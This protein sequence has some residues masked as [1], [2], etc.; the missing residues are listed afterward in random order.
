[1]NAKLFCAAAVLAALGLGASAEAMAS[2]TSSFKAVYSVRKS[3]LPLGDAHF[4]LEPGKQNGCYVYA[5]HAKPNALVHMFLG[6]IDDETRFCIVDGAVRPMY[7]RHHIDGK[8]GHSYTLKFDWSAMTVRYHSEN[9][10]T[11]TY[12]LKPGTQDPMSLQIAARRWLA[13]AN[14]G[15]GAQLPT[16][17]AFTLADDDGLQTYRVNVTDAG[18]L[19]TPGG[20]FDTVRLARTGQHHHALTFWLARN[21]D[22]IPVQVRRLEDGDTQY[23]LTVQSLSRSDG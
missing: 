12:T 7:F 13:D 5:G 22:W 19:K 8:P 17:H 11:K 6:N 4:S 3:G 10:D 18:N 20:T 16:E 2:P 21:A 14:S 9:G 23:E 1:M 15:T